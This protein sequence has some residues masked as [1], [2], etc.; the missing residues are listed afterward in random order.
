MS[1]LMRM[2]MPS[3]DTVCG[4]VFDLCGVWSCPVMNRI[5]HQPENG[6]IPSW[7]P[8]I[9][10]LPEGHGRLVDA[11]AMAEDFDFDV[12]NDQ[13][14]LDDMYIVGYERTR[15]QFDKDCKQK[16]MWYLS[17]APTI[18]PAAAERSEL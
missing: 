4:M 18:V 1:V 3:K 7:C 10:Q 8:I 16:C 9:C 5:C 6:D 2:R 17:E 12:E 14:A 15:L 11:D 13:R